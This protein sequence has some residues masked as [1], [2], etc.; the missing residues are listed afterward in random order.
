[1]AIPPQ[2]D[3]RREGRLMAATTHHRDQTAAADQW[4]IP[5]VLASWIVVLLCGFLVLI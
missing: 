4:V 1:M 2:S 3:Q 5:L